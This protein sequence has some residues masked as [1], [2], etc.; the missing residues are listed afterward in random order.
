[1]LL[2]KMLMSTNNIHVNKLI[3]MKFIPKQKRKTKADLCDKTKVLLGSFG[4]NEM[5][6]QKKTLK[7]YLKK[8]S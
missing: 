7:F 1:M 2:S 6:N 5:Q 4:Q 8:L 3:K